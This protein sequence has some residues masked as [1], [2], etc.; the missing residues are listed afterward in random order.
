MSC[1]PNQFFESVPNLKYCFY[2]RPDYTG[3][4]NKDGGENDTS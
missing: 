2:H 1:A 3:Q 4:K